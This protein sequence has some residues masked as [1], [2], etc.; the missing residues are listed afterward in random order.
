[1]THESDNRD[2]KTAKDD[3]NPFG[4]AA[5][6]RSLKFRHWAIG[7]AAAAIVVLG[8]ILIFRPALAEREPAINPLDA[9]KG[10]EQRK[11]PAM[12]KDRLAAQLQV[13]E[14]I[15][16]ETVARRDKQMLLELFGKLQETSPVDIRDWDFS[17]LSEGQMETL[18]Q[19][20]RS[21]EPTSADFL[22]L[23]S[24]YH[25]LK[26]RISGLEKRLGQPRVVVSGDTHFQIVY[27]FLSVRTGKSAAE[28]QRI[29]QDTQ[30]QD[31]L[32]P[33]FKVWNFWLP[34]GF[35]TFVTQGT[36]HLTPAETARQAKETALVRLNSLFYISGSVTG[37]HERKTL[38]S[39]FLKSTR[40]AEISPGQFRLSIDLRSQQHIRVQ[41]AAL[42]LKKVS[43]LTIFPREFNA[44]KD[45]AVRLGPRGNWIQVT[46]LKKRIFRGR[47]IVIAVE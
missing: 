14:I 46:I 30:F 11:Q 12:F 47:R 34:D 3:T 40:L 18:R 29:I 9:A 45:Y 39:G 5:L 15:A 25:S 44:G 35:C 10:Q 17:N 22:A 6:R 41:A 20:A 38:I 31:P 23:S 36:A 16:M 1:M 24:R 8:L 26:N 43:A 21:G 2:L 42:Q 33:G 19:R 37:L 27:D 7:I 13:N 28:A 32:L 4:R